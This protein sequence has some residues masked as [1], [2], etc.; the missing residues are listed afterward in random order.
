MHV[1]ATSLVSVCGALLLATITSGCTAISTSSK[2]TNAG[3]D[4]TLSACRLWQPGRLNKRIRL[5]PTHSGVA[6]CLKRQGWLP[7]GQVV[8]SLPAADQSTNP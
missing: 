8:V 6:R 2:S 5:P 7:D 3:F 1:V 4:S